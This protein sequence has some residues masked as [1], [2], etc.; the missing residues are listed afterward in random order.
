MTDPWDERYIYLHECLI[1]FVFFK[2]YMSYMDPIGLVMLER[3]MYYSILLTT[4]FGGF[5]FVA[6]LI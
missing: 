1:F 3:F 6:K 5:V 4:F 2:V